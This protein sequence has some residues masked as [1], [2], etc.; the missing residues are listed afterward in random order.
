MHTSICSRYMYMIDFL[1]S[2]KPKLCQHRVNMKSCV[3][4]ELSS[5]R[6]V[7]CCCFFVL[8]S[9]WF[10]GMYASSL[11]GGLAAGIEHITNNLRWWRNNKNMTIWQVRHFALHTLERML[12]LRWRPEDDSKK[13][14]NAGNGAGNG[15]GHAGQSTPVAGEAPPLTLAEKEQL[16]ESMLQ[17]MA[18]GTRDVAQEAQFIKIKVRW[19]VVQNCWLSFSS[20]HLKLIYPLTL[21]ASR[22]DRFP[23]LTGVLYFTKFF[24]FRR[25]KN[26]ETGIFG[27]DFFQWLISWREAWG[28]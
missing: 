9:V 15:S 6:G 1:R 14:K 7:V 19:G 25:W 3:Q 24:P 8:G 4:E 28:H 20:M 23:W 13:K 10:V 5:R 11:P 2:K 21:L 26:K 18:M 16:K 17:V 22:G 12:K 27:F